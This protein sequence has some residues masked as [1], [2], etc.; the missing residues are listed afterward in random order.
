M[1][2]LLEREHRVLEEIVR[3][4]IRQACP[5]SSQHIAQNGSISLSPATIRHSMMDLE[6]HGYLF[7]PHTSAGRVPTQKAYRFFVDNCID[8]EIDA[9]SA[10]AHLAEGLD[11]WDKHMRLITKKTHAFTAILDEDEV[12]HF[13]TAELFS[14]PEFARDPDLLHSFGSFMDSLADMLEAYHAA[15]RNGSFPRVFIER[16]NPVPEARRMSA[17]ASPLQGDRGVVIALGPSRMNYET[18]ITMFKYF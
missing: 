9:H 12:T 16:E 15:T 6:D 2:H 11:A 5:V 14:E 17:V 13:G 10:V 4:Y 18:I 3:A 8:E 1:G 7:Q